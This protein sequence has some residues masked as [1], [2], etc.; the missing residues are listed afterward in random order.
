MFSYDGHSIGCFAF[1]FTVVFGSQCEQLSLPF[2]HHF[3]I[4]MIVNVISVL[5]G[6]FVTFKP[7]EMSGN[8]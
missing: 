8:S 2:L 1:V 5:C 4:I 7:C 3:T 6:C